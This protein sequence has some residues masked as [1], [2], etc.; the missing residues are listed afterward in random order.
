MFSTS[1]LVLWCNASVLSDLLVEDI[2]LN[3]LLGQNLL[4]VLHNFQQ[5]I[6][7]LID[8][9]NFGSSFFFYIRLVKQRR[10][11]NCSQ[12]TIAETKNDNLG[13]CRSKWPSSFSQSHHYPAFH[14][15]SN[16]PSSFFLAAILWF[17]PHSP[18]FNDGLNCIQSILRSSFFYSTYK[19]NS[20]FNCF[21]SSPFTFHHVC[22][23]WSYL[24]KE[25]CGSNGQLWT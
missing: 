23:Y 3:W 22:T 25:T 24:G 21:I 7:K 1:T 4:N 18:M 13:N 11:T 12:M 14:K 20:F 8:G 6:E 16:L 9:I 2:C 5:Y 19:N 10:F 17:L 15:W